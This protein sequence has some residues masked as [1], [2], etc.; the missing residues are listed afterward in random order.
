MPGAAC[1]LAI[2]VAGVSSIFAPVSAPVDA[3][4]RAA[5]LVLV[6]AAGILVVVGGLLAYGIVAFRRSLRP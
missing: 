6:I 4:L 2:V 1:G 3:S 5:L